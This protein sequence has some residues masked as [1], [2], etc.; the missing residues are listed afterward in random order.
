MLFSETHLGNARKARKGETF[1]K[2]KVLASIMCVAMTAGALAGC[3]SSS[4]ET[5]STDSASTETAAEET[6]EAA[7]D[8]A[9]ETASTDA[10]EDSG[11]INIF[12]S[13]PE[14]AD[15]I[16]T[17]IEEY[18]TVAP[19]VTINYETTQNDYPTMLKAKINSGDIPDIF[20]STSGKEIDTYLEYSYDLTGQPL[21]DAMDPGVAEAMKSP[22]T[23]TGVYGLAIK[24][25][26]FGIVYNKDIFEAAGI[27]SFPQTVSE[28]K[29]ACDKITAAGYTP[30]TT[31]YAEWW[32]FKH[33][34]QSFL[35][36][37]AENA[38][39]TSAELVSK[40][41]NGEA[42]VADYPELY[43]NWFDFVDLTVQYGD[44]K[45]LETDLSAEEAA[46]ATGQVAMAVGQGAWIEADVLNINP[47]FNLGFDGYPTTEDAS[48]TKVITGSDQA[49]RVYKDSDNLQATLN[50][51]NYWYTSEY[52]QA[53]FTDVAGV[54]PP[55]TTDAVS[56]F[57]VIK[58]GN[59]LAASEGV[60]TLAIIYS[61]DTWHQAFGQIMQSYI[62]GTLDKDQACAQ[63]EEQ[64]V[65]TDGASE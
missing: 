13:Q 19:N 36:S 50:F 45:P 64:W 4:T 17:L 62:A 32:V 38:G 65:A 48:Q 26:Y 54:V 18:K 33:A 39:I 6:T 63:I 56:D 1:M 30:F 35:N 31:G 44:D 8:T 37:A 52:G 9:A 59:D 58:Q 11:E 7:D 24:G 40:F 12:I 20:S 15:A 28:L 14:Y 3:G 34:W 23:G 27:S 29:D 49:L 57:E 5:A 53:W 46:L 55:I 22:S 10:S 16:N 43:D 21:V 60:G 2:K 41:E 61:T 47:D 25:N 51:L 42:K